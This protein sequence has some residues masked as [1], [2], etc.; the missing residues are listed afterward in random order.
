MPALGRDEDQ[1]R[2]L[3]GFGIG[4]TASL[5]QHARLDVAPLG[6]VGLELLRQR[7]RFIG[8]VGREQPRAE[9]GAPDAPARIDARPQQEAQM[10]GPRPLVDAGAFGQRSKARIAALGQHFQ[11]LCHQRPVDAGQR[12][13][14]ADRAE[15]HQIE[16]LHHVGLEAL[17]IVPALGP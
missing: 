17:R 7:F 1:M 15:C 4:E 6:I 2:P 16:P 13:D 10:I 11:P 5:F 8:I 9:I 12:H 14:I 3:D